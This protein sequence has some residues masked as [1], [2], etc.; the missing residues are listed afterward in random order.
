MHG[1]TN[2]INFYNLSIQSQTTL[3]KILFELLIIVS[4]AQVWKLKHQNQHLDSN[5]NDE[6]KNWSCRVS[7]PVP[8]PC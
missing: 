6:S 2:S 5:L 7:I 4:F 3:N 1:L 8:L